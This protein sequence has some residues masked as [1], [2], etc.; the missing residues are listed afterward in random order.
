MN[1]FLAGIF[2]LIIGAAGWYYLFYS[3]AAEKLKGVED[4]RINQRRVRLRRVGGF[5]MILL[6][7]AMYAGVAGFD[8]NSEHPSMWFGLVWVLVMG[9]VFVITVL[10]LVDVRLTRQ[11]R[12]RRKREQP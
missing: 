12:E 4:A 11:L 2:A 9:L 5:C 7:M 3:K 8:W 1:P 10:A 6:A